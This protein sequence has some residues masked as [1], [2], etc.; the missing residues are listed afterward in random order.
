MVSSLA[1]G[2]T[3]GNPYAEKALA[4]STPPGLLRVVGSSNTQGLPGS[5]SIPPFRRQPV[6][7]DGEAVTGPVRGLCLQRHVLVLGFGI[8]KRSAGPPEPGCARLAA[9][10]C[11]RAPEIVRGP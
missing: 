4:Y 1:L 5:S 7:P 10:T 11:C 8:S 2:R 9:S 3:M 6:S